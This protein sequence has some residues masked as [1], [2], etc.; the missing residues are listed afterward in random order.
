MLHKPNRLRPFSGP[1]A[2]LLW[3]QWR[4]FIPFIGG[5]L[6]TEA[7]AAA[8][9][10]IN[11]VQKSISLHDAVAGA[12]VVPRL[13]SALLPAL[14]CVT[15]ASGIAFPGRLY[16]LPVTT[17]RMVLYVAVP[18]LVLLLATLLSLF[19]FRTLFF[20]LPDGGEVLRMTVFSVEAL[21]ACLALSWSLG[22]FRNWPAVLGQVLVVGM[23]WSLHDILGNQETRDFLGPDILW[24]VAGLWAVLWILVIFAGPDRARSGVSLLRRLRSGVKTSVQI[25]GVSGGAIQ[26]R[27]FASPFEAQVW[28]ERR[29]RGYAG[30]L[31]PLLFA[32]FVVLLAADVPIARWG[33]FVPAY[34]LTIGI[35]ALSVAA[36]FVVAACRRLMEAHR[37]RNGRFRF[38]AAKPVSTEEL[39]RARFHAMSRGTGAAVLFAVVMTAF[40][41]L[42]PPTPLLFTPS[43]WPLWLADAYQSLDGLAFTWLLIW[44]LVLWVCASLTALS[45]PKVLAI[46]LAWPLLQL[47]TTY[48]PV[49]DLM[50]YGGDE[51]VIALTGLCLAVH[52]AGMFYRAQRRG[53]ISPVTVLLC[54]VAYMILAQTLTPYL[55]ELVTW[56]SYRWNA[57]YIPQTRFMAW[58]MEVLGVLTLAVAPFAA[59]PLQ[60]DRWRH[61]GK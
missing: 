61:G 53:L 60:F 2:A 10:Y 21:V 23:A 5:A 32:V 31:Y 26:L 19:G 1:T 34:F 18:R 48:A 28:Y 20:G 41:W 46:L 52:V 59:L 15:P 39:A 58:T 13:C 45:T 22:A 27:R 37:V 56:N 50:Y 17:R 3:E 40:F 7:A 55:A 35:V 54:A 24:P 9:L 44:L 33:G 6:F 14:L 25:R 8:G 36:C 49:R 12:D 11:L 43:L 38:L 47:G 51:V 29:T 30:L 16:R 57:T 42:L 4:L